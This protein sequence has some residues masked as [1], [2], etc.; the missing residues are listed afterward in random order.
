MNLLGTLAEWAG[1]GAGR[2]NASAGPRPQVIGPQPQVTV[3][4][5]PRF[6]WDQKGWSRALDGDTWRYQGTYRVYDFRRR[7]WRTFNGCLLEGRGVITAFCADPPTEIK[8]HP[9][10]PC[11]MLAKAPWFRVN[12]HRAPTSVDEALIY[13]ERLLDECLNDWRR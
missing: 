4:P 11:F 13:V 2:Q 3:A 9:K 5:P 8:S 7:E 1:V 10:G 12:W 6:A